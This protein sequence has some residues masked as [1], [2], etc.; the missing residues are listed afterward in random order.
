MY[1]IGKLIGSQ[2][3]VWATPSF[4]RTGVSFSQLVT[5]ALA[6][7]LPTVSH[8]THGVPSNKPL[9]GEQAVDALKGVKI[10]IHLSVKV[11][12]IRVI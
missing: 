1:G 6:K 2:G 12:K 3:G 4:R 5:C 9:Q 7:T 11:G 8:A 10:I